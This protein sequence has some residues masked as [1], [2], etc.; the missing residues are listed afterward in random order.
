MAATLSFD[1]AYRRCRR[2]ELDPVYYLTGD[3]DILKDELIA[4]LAEQVVDPSTRDFNYDVRAAPDVDAESLH[5]LVETPPMLAERRM[6]VLRGVDQWRKNA[7]V[8]KVLESYVQ[9]P[10]PSTVLVITAGAGAKPHAGL[11]GSTAH[12]A[13]EPLPPDRLSRWVRMRAERAGITLDG[14]A[15]RHLIAAVGGD[16]AQLGLE[17]EKLAAA[18]TGGSVSAE[19]VA[20]LVGVRRGETADDWIRATLERDA[21]RAIGMLGPVLGASGNSAVRLVGMLGTALIG[22]RL[23]RAQLDGGTRRGEVERGMMGQIKAARPFG[24]GPWGAAAKRWT[25]LAERWSAAELNDALR[26]TY[27]ADRALKSTTIADETGILTD[28]LL[29]MSVREAA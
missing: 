14:E 9:R 27:A 4:L 2:G 21:A 28:M 5:A 3:E 7:K 1:T 18:V 19:D 22:V 17:I 26:S 29:K 25:A 11:A 13:V 6:V 8:W 10:A 16:L 24:I 12:V 23:A 20:D 15:G